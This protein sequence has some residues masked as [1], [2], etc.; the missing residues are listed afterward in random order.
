[1]KRNSRFTIYRMASVGVMAAACFA[2]TYFL[3]IDIVTPIGPTMIK[4]GNAFCLLAGLLLGPLSGG[5]AAGLGCMFFDLLNPLYI[6][7][8]PIT[9]INYFAMAAVAGLIAHLGGRRGA[10]LGFN[11]AGGILGAL[12]Y[13]L[14]YAAKSII[15]LLLEGSALTPALIS[16]ATSKLPVSAIN[17]VVGTVVAVVLCAALRPALQRAGLYKRLFKE[18]K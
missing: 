14:L 8:A 4:L 17:G 5:L 1:M 6:S 13:I 10:S 16:F 2:A 15:G 12:T 9:F 7:S 11:I 18:E 3:K